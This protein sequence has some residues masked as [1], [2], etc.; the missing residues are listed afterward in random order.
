MVLAKTTNGTIFVRV[1][2]H[3]RSDDGSIGVEMNSIRTMTPQLCNKIIGKEGDL[4]TVPID[5]HKRIKRAVRSVLSVRQRHHSETA[6]TLLWTH[7][8]I[9]V[10]SSAHS[11][12]SSTYLY[13]SLPNLYFFGRSLQAWSK[14]HRPGQTY[15][16]TNA[17]ALVDQLCIPSRLL[18]YI[19][20]VF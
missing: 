20:I 8:I 13:T 12:S 14:N 3:E 6:F 1:W 10:R 9:L 18:Y 7:R 4:I 15:N 16:N 5:N 2:S 17:N 19:L 11:L